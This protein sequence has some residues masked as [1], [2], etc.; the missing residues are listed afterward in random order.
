MSR[1]GKKP[2]PL[3]KGV[4]LSISDRL[5]RMEGP[6]GKLELNVHPR[7]SIQHDAAMHDL[8]TSYLTGISG[9]GLTGPFMQYTHTG[10]CWGLKEKTSDSVD[11]SPK[12]KGVLDWLAAH[13]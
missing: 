9:A 4:K 8:Y 6:K 2:V 7:I 12:Y 5:V 10:S 11:V 1:I 3:A 13:P